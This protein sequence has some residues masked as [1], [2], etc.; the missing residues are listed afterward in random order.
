Q[1][2]PI[3]AKRSVNVPARPP[4]RRKKRVH[5]KQIS[6]LTRSRRARTAQLT[7]R[8]ASVVIARS[9]KCKDTVAVNAVFASENRRGEDRIV[10]M[11]LT[12][13]PI[14][15]KR[16]VLAV[17]DGYAM[18]WRVEDF[19]RAWKGGLCRVEDMQLRSRDAIFKWATILAAVATRAT[20]LTHL[21]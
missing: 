13:H 4:R 7:I 5:G 21:A 10:W 15:T 17:V 3:R 14:R 6:Y 16:D 19:H 12:T 11:L 1:R 18:R 8:A 2:A 9:N 20:R